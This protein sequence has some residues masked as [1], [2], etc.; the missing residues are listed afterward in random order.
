MVLPTLEAA[1]INLV[2]AP[3]P[4]HMSYLFRIPPW[5]ISFFLILIS[6]VI[7]LLI[8]GEVAYEYDNRP[9]YYHFLNR[10]AGYFIAL[11]CIMSICLYTWFTA[12]IIRFCE[13][14]KAAWFLLVP[15]L[16]SIIFIT[17]L[18]LLILEEVGNY[19]SYFTAL[20]KPVQGFMQRVGVESFFLYGMGIML[21]AG[22]ITILCLVR[23]L[24]RRKRDWL[25]I[26][27]QMLLLPI[28]V[29]WLQPRLRSLLDRKS[30]T[31]VEEHFV[32]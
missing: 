20:A 1:K 32:A 8:Y 26:P 9:D 27:V 12:I 5:L 23:L 29:L 10:N 2:Y 3:K 15:G 22:L 13:S 25:L 7:G 17:M 31:E 21:I 4:P 18:L 30:V 11:F 6:A 24:Y 28:G 16:A 14:R 19:N